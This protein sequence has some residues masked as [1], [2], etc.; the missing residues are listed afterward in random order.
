MMDGPPLLDSFQHAGLPYRQ[1]QIVFIA[2]LDL[3]SEL[4]FVF[5]AVGPV[6][7]CVNC[8]TSEV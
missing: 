2:N 4:L 7:V 6:C 3:E 8:A 5:H 1:R